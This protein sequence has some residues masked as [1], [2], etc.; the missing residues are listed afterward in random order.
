MSEYNTDKGI[1]QLNAVW[2]LFSFFEIYLITIG[3]LDIFNGII[4]VVGTFLLI[5][6]VG[7]KA[8]LTKIENMVVG[9][10]AKGQ[11]DR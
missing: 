10:R 9:E 1:Q 6:Y 11:W 4:F 3:R 5:W 7:Q 8:K 2:V